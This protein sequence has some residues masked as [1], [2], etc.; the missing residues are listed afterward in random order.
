MDTPSRDKY[1][2]EGDLVTVF[3]AGRQT[4]IL[5]GWF[6]WPTRQYHGPREFVSEG[7]NWPVRFRKCFFHQYIPV[8][9]ILGAKYIH[10]NKTLKI[11]VCR[12]QRCWRNYCMRKRNKAASLIQTVFRNCISNPYHP[13]C[14]ARLLREF[15]SMTNESCV[16]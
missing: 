5:D 1:W 16:A 3:I 13:M 9:N 8:A 4:G 6:T 2:R 14:R 7:M 12:I 10:E 11:H 15:H